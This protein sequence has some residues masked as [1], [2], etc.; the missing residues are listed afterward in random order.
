MNIE[1]T[2]KEFEKEIHLDSLSKYQTSLAE[3]TKKLNK[4]YY[5][6]D[7][8]DDHRIIVGSIGRGTAVKGVSDVDM[9]FEMPREVYNRFNGHD[10]NKQSDLLQ[11]IRSVLKDRYPRTEIRGD[12][13]VV[14]V[15]FDDY[16]IEIVPGF[17]EDDD[18]FTYPDS[19]DGGSW[20][21]TDPLPEQKAVKEI[22]GKCSYNNMVRLCNMLR[23]WKNHRGF[24][25][26]G[27]LI[28][29]LAY[30]FLTEQSSHRHD[31]Y[32]DSIKLLKAAFNYLSKE[33]P[34][35]AYWLALGSNQQVYNSGEGRFVRK[36]KTAYNKLENARD[37]DDK[38]E[39]ALIYIFGHTFEQCIVENT[40]KMANERNHIV[41]R[42]P[43]ED[44]IDEIM[45]VDIR[46]SVKIDCKVTQNG[47]RDYL[48][49][50]VLNNTL[51]RDLSLHKRLEFYIAKTN[52]PKPYDVYWKVR[53][54][55]VESAGRERGQILRGKTCQ[56]E[57]S[58]F[59]G[60]HYVEC[61]IAKDGVCVARDRIDVP[62]NSRSYDYAHKL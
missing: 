54:R 32:A 22:T 15:I 8:E 11:E 56:I 5:D 29:T 38:I 13:Q 1:K 55:G 10:G 36:A 28:D 31:G 52:V 33:D 46:Y 21:K 20:K 16:T 27:L 43:F 39:D 44:F 4:K 50:A 9:I 14:D 34:D 45:P 7:S 59:S 40:T 19:N 12:G 47:F 35:Q 26:G 48:L 24:P 37:D 42:A 61:F 41:A 3:I 62:I 17:R 58:H 51:L 49:R 60:D 57:H 53:N 18:S 30:N 25:F 6:S 23:I 2:F